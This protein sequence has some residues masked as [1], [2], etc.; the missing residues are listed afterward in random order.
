MGISVVENNASWGLYVWELDNGKVFG[1]SDGNVM[2]IPGKPFDV[3]L[4]NKITQ[5]AR[6]YGAPPGHA[7]FMPGVQR[8]S[9]MRHSEEVDR[10]KEGLIPSESDIGMWQEEQA[11]FEEYQ[12]KGWDWQNG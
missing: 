12:R 4:M 11:L 3:A 2:N 7:K 9:E 10:M 6:H 1:D 5:A 8:V